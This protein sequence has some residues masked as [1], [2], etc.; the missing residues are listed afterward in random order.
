M[1]F[2]YV[3][4]NSHHTLAS[5][6]SSFDWLSLLLSSLLSSVEKT[7]HHLSMCFFQLLNFYNHYFQFSL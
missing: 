5:R 6:F 1:T 2:Y 4:V 3:T 7:S